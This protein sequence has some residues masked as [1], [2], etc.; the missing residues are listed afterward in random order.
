ME[1]NSIEM[2][3]MDA[4]E[5]EQVQ[6]IWDAIPQ[7]DR[8]GLTQDDILFVLDS[9]DNYLE[10]VG[11]LIEDE[12]TGEMIYQEGEVDETEQLDFVLQ[13]AKKDK[14]TITAVQI[15]I[16]LDAELQYGI[17]NGWYEEED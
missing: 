4:E 7:Q 10:E 5:R 8:Q 17:E 11:L 9:V 12:Q 13:E 3:L 6:F 15:Q 1:N 14:R 2:S 16:I